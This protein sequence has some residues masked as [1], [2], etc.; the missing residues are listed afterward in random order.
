MSSANLLPDDMKGIG[1]VGPFNLPSG[2]KR[3][4]DLAFISGP[5]DLLQNNLLVKQLGELFRSGQIEQYNSN[6]IVSGNT[7]IHDLASS[8]QYSIPNLNVGAQVIWSINNGLIINGQGT[9][10]ITVSWGLNGVGELKAEIIDSLLPCK[11]IG[12]L[13]VEIG[14]TNIAENSV[15]LTV[16]IYPNPTR[17]IIQIESENNRIAMIRV[18]DLNGRVID[19]K[20]YDGTYDSSNLCQG[21]YVLELIGENSLSLVRKMFVK[22]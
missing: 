3:S 11:K 17:S 15:N 2:S 13:I 18:L 22:Q 20:K 7:Q 19:D 5:H 6:V 9:S 8:Y 21:I 10:S 1:S 12:K 16:R 4:F 14:I